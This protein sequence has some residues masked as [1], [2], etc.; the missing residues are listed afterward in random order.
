MK[1]DIPF[2]VPAAVTLA[3]RG[4]RTI[5]VAGNGSSNRATALLAV[6]LAGEKL[7]VFLISKGKRG[8]RVHKEVTGLDL[9]RRAFPTEVIMSVQENAWMDTTLMK[10][11]IDRIWERWLCARSAIYSYLIM[12]AFSAH[13]EES[14][15]G[16]LGDCGIEVG[17]GF[18]FYVIF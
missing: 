17:S 7:P 14:V 4:C 3:P 2:D 11:W 8:A 15:I 10:E 18:G 1:T 5:L 13:L 9:V 6:T 12:D 16:K